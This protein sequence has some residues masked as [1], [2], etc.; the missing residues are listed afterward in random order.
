MFVQMVTGFAGV[1]KQVRSGFWFRIKL[2][3]EA[4]LVYEEN[5]EIDEE[6]IGREHGFELEQTI[7]AL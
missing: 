7:V 2:W 4:A 6:V 1:F 5:P 3:A